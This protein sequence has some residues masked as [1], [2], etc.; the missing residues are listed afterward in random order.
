MAS[1]RVTVIDGSN[2]AH[3]EKT[4]KGQPKVSNL[5]AV[6][7]ALEDQGLRPIIIVDAS[8]RHLVDDPD[9]LEALVNHQDVLQAPAGTDADYFVLKT[10]DE[11]KGLVIS[12]DRYQP[13]REAYPWLDQRRI[14][15]M[16]VEGNVM[17]YEK[18]L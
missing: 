5:I 6:R 1:A 12:N 14:S 2:V 4:K 18:A 17:L 9:Q 16:I 10:A 3:L 8:L 13:Y 15:L 7:R 11:M